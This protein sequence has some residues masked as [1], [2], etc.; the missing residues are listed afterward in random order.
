MVDTLLHWLGYGLCHQLP[1]R[2]FFAGTHQVPVCARDTGIYLGFMLSF[3]VIALIARGRRP[4]ELPPWPVIALAVA[5]IGLMAADGVSSYAGWRG[6]TNDIRLA[7]G[8]LAGYAM[9]A[10][11]V[12][13]L[14]GQLWR[15]PGPDRVLGER[16]SVGWWLL[17]L[18]IAF[19]LIR[20]PFEWLGI[21]YPLL[22]AAAIIG[23]FTIV[24]LAIV[25][26]LPVAEGRSERL[27]DVWP[28]LLTAFAFT[29]VEI[30]ASAWLKLFLTGL[31]SSIR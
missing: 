21:A 1:E 11:L 4:S 31:T 13:I 27:R 29:V 5:F 20:W 24:N 26:V 15:R 12:P 28:W 6:T 8:L 19:V 25:S 3:A 22:V 17:P 2:S 18:P 30:A 16:R 10:L 14:N 7:T 9:P 23:T